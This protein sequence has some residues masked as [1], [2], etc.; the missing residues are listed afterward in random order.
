MGRFLFPALKPVSMQAMLGVETLPVNGAS[1]NLTILS[2]GAGGGVELGLGKAFYIGAA[3]FGGYWYGFFP[4]SSGTISDG[5]FFLGASG[6]LGYKLNDGFRVG[7]G[8]SYRHHFYPSGGIYDGLSIGLTSGLKI[9]S[10][11]KTPL[12]RIDPIRLEPIFPVFY[13]YYN[14]HPLGSLSVTNKEPGEIRQ[15]TVNLFVPQYMDKPKL[16]ASIATIAEGA[17]VEVPLYGLFTDR[18]LEITEGTKVTATISI[19]YQ[20]YD[21]KKH[22]EHHDVM[23]LNNRNAM[24]WNDDRKAAS[25][26]TAKDPAVL[27]FA[28][29]VDAITKS[30]DGVGMNQTIRQGIAIADSIAALGVNY[31]VDPSSPFTETSAN[32]QAVDF[33]QF[34]AQTLSYRAGDCDD[35]SILY[36]SLMEA[37]GVKTAF[38]T[39]PGH[40]YAAFSLDMGEEEARKY[41]YGSENLIYAN[42]EAWVPVEITILD[43]GFAA[44]CQKGAEQWRQFSSDGKAKLFAVRESWKL[45]APVGMKSD[46][47]SIPMDFLPRLETV[48]R[49]SLRRTTDALI[50]AEEKRLLAMLGKN[51]DSTNARNFLGVLY[52]KFGLYEKAE[53]EFEGLLVK[54]DTWPALVNLANLRLLQGRGGDALE[55]FQR[56]EMKAPDNSVVIVGLAKAHFALGQFPEVKELYAK[57]AAKDEKLAEKYAYL[58]QGSG[59]GNRAS[60]AGIAED[61]LWSEE[62]GD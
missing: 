1:A 49:E 17:T 42:G 34:P 33:L 36:C 14:D 51:P 59:E 31:A 40:I 61:V 44:A 27:K 60:S 8:L 7:L 62:E 6:E 43:R 46:A 2:L 11:G 38:I 55:L 22:L 15:V 41:F 5:S 3:G 48:Y 28:R 47:D 21:V 13:S 12:L 24:T 18:V 29:N 30:Q 32:S 56:A 35:L 39:V 16:C 4:S 26:V 19:D 37:L 50:G 25:F 52:A 58:A 10:G 54:A 9:R 45:Y 53:R 57:I 23:T 20:Y